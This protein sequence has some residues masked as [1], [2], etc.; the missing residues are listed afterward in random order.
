MA[1]WIIIALLAIL[2]L[3]T[4]LG[5]GLAILALWIAVALAVLAAAGGAVF[6]IFV[7]LS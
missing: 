5:Q 1:L 7:A 3:S 4:E 2:A 6:A